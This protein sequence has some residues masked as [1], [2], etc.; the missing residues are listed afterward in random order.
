M[1]YFLILFAYFLLWSCTE[2]PGSLNTPNFVNQPINTI[3][4][5]D[6]E[7]FITKNNIPADD[8]TYAE[9]ALKI[10]KRLFTNN[11]IVFAT[12]RGTFTNN[13]N[14]YVVVSSINDTVFVYI[15]HSKSESIRLTANVF[16]NYFK[17]IIVTFIPALPDKI[18]INS[19][20]NSLP[21]SF[22]SRAQI[23]AKLIKLIGTVSEGQ[24]VT[25]YDSIENCVSANCVGAFFNTTLSDNNGLA[26]SEYLLQDKNFHGLVYIIG[27]IQ[28]SS[29][30]IIRGYNRI[31]IE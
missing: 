14:K 27:S 6:V 5:N 21:S 11:E 23:T 24:S 8:Y 1:K 29:G 13:S 25:F 31:L 17:E 7:L 12:D 9:I 10:N 30:M 19:N 15:K 3:N 2:E 28:T 16:G 20:A 18:Y 22:S 4:T 26:S